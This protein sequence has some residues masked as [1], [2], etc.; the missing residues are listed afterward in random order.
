MIKMK[1]Q[2]IKNLILFKLLIIIE[3]FVQ[4]FSFNIFQFV[5]F[6]LSIITLKIKGT[7]EKNVFSYSY[8]Q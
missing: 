2:F 6:Q 3:F 5:K 1:N 4:A 8:Q 7:G